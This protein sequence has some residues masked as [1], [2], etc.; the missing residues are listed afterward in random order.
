MSEK[1][2]SQISQ[3]G[4]ALP[5]T[6]GLVDTPRPA[7]VGAAKPEK[8]QESGA[9]PDER[10]SKELAGIKVNANKARPFGDVT[11]RFEID[12]QT[13]DVTIL[14]LDKASQKVVR[15][16]PPEEMARMDPGELLQLFA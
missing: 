1:I 7:Q 2:D 11:L 9:S 4:N 6:L 13:H 15:T 3:A 5:V 10:T 16:I 8:S 12:S 14:I